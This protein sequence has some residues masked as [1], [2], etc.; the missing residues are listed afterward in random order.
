[1]LSTYSVVK[2]SG[3]AALL[4]VL[5]AIPAAGQ[6]VQDPPPELSFLSTILKVRKNIPFEIWGEVKFPPNRDIGPARHGKHWFILAEAANGADMVAEWNRIKPVFLQ[7]GWTLVKEYRTGGL[8]EVL[9]YAKNDVEAWANVDNDFANFRL[10][11]IEITPLPFILTLAASRT[12]RLFASLC[13]AP[14]R[15]KWWRTERSSATTIFPRFRTCCSPQ[16]TTTRS[17]KPAG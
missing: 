13:P 6:F 11:V 7:N 17:Q 15:R 8:L 10:D 4:C 5:A 9:P 2:I 14:A 3:V 12:T 16:P 1:M